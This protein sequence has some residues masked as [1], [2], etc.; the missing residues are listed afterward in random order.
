[1][2]DENKQI[3]VVDS[4]FWTPLYV[5]K[6]LDTALGTAHPKSNIAIVLYDTVVSSA[7]Q[8][9]SGTA[10]IIRQSGC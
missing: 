7:A 5:D 9:D 1:M 4:N 2:N 6:R 10:S 3:L 8:T